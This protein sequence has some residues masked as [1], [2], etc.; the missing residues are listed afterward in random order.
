V[1]F[2]TPVS[3][4]TTMTVSPGL[5]MD[6]FVRKRLYSLIR[7]FFSGDKKGGGTGQRT[8]PILGIGG[9]SRCG[10]AVFPSTLTG[11]EEEGSLV[12]CGGVPFSV[13]IGGAG[14]GDFPAWGRSA[15]GLVFTGVGLLS[16][17]MGD[18]V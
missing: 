16:V 15:A 4:I 6:R 1:L 9:S 8:C 12:S 18:S 13:L 5:W 10:A 7:F 14:T 17:R 3:P 2:P 11:G